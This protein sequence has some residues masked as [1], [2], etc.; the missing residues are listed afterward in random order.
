MLHQAAKQIRATQGADGAMRVER[1]GAL[2]LTTARRSCTTRISWLSPAVIG[3][4]RG[5][6]ARDVVLVR[7]PGT[8]ADAHRR[9][10]SP[11]GPTAPTRAAALDQVNDAPR[12]IIIAKSDIYQVQHD[13]VQHFD[14]GLLQAI[15]DLSRI[16]AATV[17]ELRQAGAAQRLQCRLD[18]FGS[19]TPR[20]IERVVHSIAV[21]AGDSKYAPLIDIA[22]PSASRTR[23]KATPES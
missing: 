17:H 23:T 20:A 10:T 13:V 18:L 7:R 21:T 3:E 2:A 15:R 4:N 6:R 11:S 22:R 12:G 9:P 1:H 5:D 14:A 19:S 16:P 8:D